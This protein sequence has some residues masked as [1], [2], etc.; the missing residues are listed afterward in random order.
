MMLIGTKTYASRRSI[1]IICGSRSKSLIPLASGSFLSLNNAS[2][3]ATN[4]LK[5]LI[6]RIDVYALTNVWCKLLRFLR[7]EGFLPREHFEKQFV[8]LSC[9]GRFSISTKGE[10]Q[11]ILTHHISLV[12]SS[13]TMLNDDF[14]SSCKL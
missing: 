10:H 12:D 14:Y 5:R 8:L 3:A 4:G 1:R 7:E 6:M 11:L 2:Q 9:N 13:N